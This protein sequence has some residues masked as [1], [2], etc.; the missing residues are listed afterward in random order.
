MG[1]HATKKSTS[2]VPEI[3]IN[4]FVNPPVKGYSYIAFYQNGILLKESDEDMAQTIKTTCKRIRSG[5]LRVE[6][7]VTGKIIKT[8]LGS[9]K[10]GEWDFNIPFDWSIFVAYWYDDIIGDDLVMMDNG[11][12]YGAGPQDKGKLYKSIKF[13]NTTTSDLWL[14][15]GRDQPTK[16]KST[17]EYY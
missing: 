9:K 15:F 7:V 12:V 11:A 13:K 5:E 6:N 3:K 8:F 10:C 4:I 17:F 14:N 16:F 2:L 1:K